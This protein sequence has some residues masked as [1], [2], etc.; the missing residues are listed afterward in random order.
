VKSLLVELKHVHEFEGDR[1]ISSTGRTHSIEAP[2]GRFE[3]HNL[4][5]GAWLVAVGAPDHVAGKELRLDMPA[6]VPTRDF[7][8]PRAA[9]VQGLV[10]DTKGKP[11][12]GAVV[13]VLAPGE[14]PPHVDDLFQDPRDELVV[15]PD[16]SEPKPR[17][18]TTDA[19]G[20]FD[21]DG[22]RPGRCILRAD[23]PGHARS[24]P[25]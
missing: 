1:V 6:D 7:V 11:V 19:Q 13:T 4:Q 5:P 3:I 18:G 9:R 16:D 15:D 14:R 17:P 12:Q 10:V 25:R 23:A 22:L 24:V 2:G 21:L 20:R 8:T